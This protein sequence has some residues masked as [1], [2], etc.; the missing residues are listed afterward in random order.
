MKRLVVAI[1]II[2]AFGGI[3]RAEDA[4]TADP[5]ASSA[6]QDNPCSTYGDGYIAVDGGKTCIRVGGRIRYDLGVGADQKPTN[7]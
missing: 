6:P 3:S 4:V 5:S 7:N 1:A 2:V